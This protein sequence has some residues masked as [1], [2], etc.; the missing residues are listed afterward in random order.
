MA[1]NI[2]TPPDETEVVDRI[3]Q[4]MRAE[5]PAVLSSRFKRFNSVVIG[6]TDAADAAAAAAGSRARR[7][8]WRRRPASSPRAFRW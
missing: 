2:G 5:F 7:A 4:T 3:A 8:R 1:I 6:F